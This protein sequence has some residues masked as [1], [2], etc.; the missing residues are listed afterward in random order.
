MSCCAPGSVSTRCRP[1][2]AAAVVGVDADGWLGA[3]LDDALH[4]TVAAVPTPPGFAGQLRP[5]QERGVGWLAFLG[6]L[7]LGAC[8]AD[9]MGLGK[10]AQLIATVLADAADGPTLVVC[11]TSVLGNWERELARFAPDARRARPPRQPTASRAHDEPFADR[12]PEH[13][14]VLT[15]YSL[16]ARDV[17]ELETVGWGRLVLDEAQQVKNPYTAQARAVHRIARRPAHRADRHA[18]REPAQRA[19]VDHARPQPGPARQR[20]LVQGA[21][22]RPDRARRAIADATARCSSGSCRRSCCAG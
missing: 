13:D 22:R 6:R 3:L 2:T 16:V 12:A 18:G 8:L 4:A 15:T 5:Y 19:V 9:D 20:P 10:T 1:P 7:G 14:V 17:D 11:P 21:L